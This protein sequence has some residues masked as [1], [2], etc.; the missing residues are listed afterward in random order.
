MLLKSYL[1][2]FVILAVTAIVLANPQLLIQSVK[3]GLIICYNNV[4]PSLYIFMVLANYRAQPEIMEI[5]SLPFRW[6]G[7]L[8]KTKDNYFAGSLVI[9]LLGGFAVGANYLNNLVQRGYSENSI[10]AM[11]VSMINNSFAFCVFVVGA[12]LLGNVFAGIIIYISLVLASMISGFIMSFFIEYN[13]VLPSENYDKTNTTIVDSIRKAVESIL[14]ICGFVIVFNFICEVLSL[15]IY[16]NILLSAFATVILE[17]TCGCLKIAS[18][19][20]KNIYFLCIALSF[21]PVCTLC[22]VYYFTQS[23]EIIK[24]LLLSRLIHTPVSLL[25]LSVLANLFPAAMTVSSQITPVVSAV[26]DSMEITSALFM[27]T[28]VFIIILDKNKLFTN[29]RL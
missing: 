8:M 26:S 1:K 25:I 19:F 11:S 18:V 16:E 6:Y 20:D 28:V 13:I 15:Y 21:L 14:V 24:T 27:I 29:N 23:K 12:N 22:Q 5:L 17:V 10:K 9:S 3:S 7:T 4:I 2:T